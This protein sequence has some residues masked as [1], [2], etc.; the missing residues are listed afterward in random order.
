MP[1]FRRLDASIRK[2]TGESDGTRIAGLRF[3]WFDGLFASFSD[4]LVAGFLELFLLSYGMSNSIIGLNASIANLCAAVSIIPGA[5]AISRTKSR[6]RLVVFTGGGAGRIGLIAIAAVPLVAGDATAAVI[7]LICL[8]AMRTAMSNFCN[9]AW[10]AMVAD[11]V[12]AESR[13]RYF[14]K[15]NVAIIVSSIIAAPLAGQIVK[16]LSDVPGFPHLGFQAIFAL[17]FV[18][19]MLSSVS[20]ARIPDAAVHEATSPKPHGFPLKA[21][22]ADRRF[23]GFVVSALVWNTALQVSAPFFNVYIVSGLGGNAAWVGIVTAV[24][25]VTTLF[26]QL[27]FTRITD[28]KGDVFAL[29]VTGLLIPLLPLSWMIVTAPEQVCIINFAS[30]ILWAGYNLANF[31]ILLKITPDDHRPEATAIYQTVVIASAAIG[32]IIGGALADSFGYKTVFATSGVG[33]YVGMLL[34]IALV[35]RPGVLRG[36]KA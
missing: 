33:R 35:I 2:I 19:G 10:T 34:F 30:G 1:F 14:G 16:S 29:V 23:L 17:S 6:R 4:N 36:K 26:G 7:C 28:R 18:I 15:R 12:P 27:A 20:F 3:F 31:N 24:S 11:L 25:S 22:L 32:P 5:L 21:L 8:N 13:A 9:P